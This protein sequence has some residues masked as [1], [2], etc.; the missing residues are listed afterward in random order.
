MRD[1]FDR[2]VG[3]AQTAPDRVAV[4]S[5]DTQLTYGELVDS[6]RHTAQWAETLPNTVALL[7]PRDRRWIIWYLAL[8]W[9]GR[10]LV[11]LPEFFSP[12]Q[13]SHIV[14]DS[15]VEAIVCP[16]E[17]QDMAAT[18]GVP[19]RIV[20]QGPEP[21]LLPSE[22]GT[23]IIYTSGT[24]GRPKGVVLTSRQLASSVAAMTQ[25]V[26]A[27][28]ED[29]MLSVLPYALLLEQ[30]A[31]I[32]VPLNV[33]GAIALCAQMTDLPLAA[34]KFS[35]TATVL[36]PE[37]LA[38]WVQWLE[39][40]GRTAPQSLRIVAVGGAPVPHKLAEKAWSLGL[41]VHE[42]YGLSECCSVVAVNRPGSRRAG[43]VGR[44]L[45]GVDVI[46]EKGEIVVCGPTVMAGYLGGLLALARHRTGDAGH[47]DEDG[48]LVVDGRIDDVVVTTTGRNI[49]P[50]WIESLLLSDPRIARCAI[51][52]GGTHPHAVLV[53]ANDWLAQATLEQR[54]ALIAELCAEA[55]AYARPARTTVLSD[56]LVR[57]HNLITGNGRLRRRAIAAHL[58]ETV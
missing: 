26:D 25:A 50:E 22:N 24:S 28:A 13:L 27:T 21:S 6:I 9:S 55:P 8:I 33:G 34:E 58:A 18:L 36:V 54:N 23:L 3:L 38:G 47:F 4:L 49:H 43:T 5:G 52:G 51:V 30:I 46:I 16:V 29:R 40:T 20:E 35:P 41:P 1:F 57:Q 37:L 42:G 7:A 19:V 12:V 15:G 56:S 14:S 53:P 2:L 45:P 48:Y 32:I 17:M 31:G 11:P 10:R 44:P 39:H